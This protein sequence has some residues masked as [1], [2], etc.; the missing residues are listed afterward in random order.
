MD[1][2]VIFIREVGMFVGIGVRV[3]V[4]EIGGGSY[5]EIWKDRSV[6]EGLL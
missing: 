4:R 2:E 3:R 5:G 6:V 1:W